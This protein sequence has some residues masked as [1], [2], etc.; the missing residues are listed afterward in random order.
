MQRS[1]DAYRYDRRSGCVPSGASADGCVDL[2]GNVW[3][4]TVSQAL[5]A[6]PD[7]NDHTWVMGGSFRHPC[8]KDGVIARNEVAI[9]NAYLYLGFRCARN[10]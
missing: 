3:E 8:M 5:A 10:V 2:V 1:A 7:T 9:D 4:W 6:F